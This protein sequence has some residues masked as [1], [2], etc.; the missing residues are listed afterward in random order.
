MERARR[1]YDHTD[2]EGSLR[3]LS[4]IPIKEAL[5]YELIGRN[6]YML[7]EY[8]KATEALE[9]AFA[10]DPGSSEI[11]LWTGR[12]FG[13]RA[14]TSSPFTAPGLASKARQFFEYGDD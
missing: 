5:S 11:A 2:F 3:V 12:A 8:K 6:Y 9:K 14:E 4:S 13:R 1:L 7:A 10:A